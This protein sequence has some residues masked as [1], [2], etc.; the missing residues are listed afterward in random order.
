MNWNTRQGYNRI[1]NLPDY[2]IQTAFLAQQRAD[3]IALAEMSYSDAD[4]MTV[5]INDL[6][7][8]T[9]KSW[10]GYYQ[11]GNTETDPKTNNVGYA[12]LTWLPV[13]SVRQKLDVDS[14]QPYPTIEIQITVN[15]TKVHIAGTH[16]YPWDAS[17]RQTQIKSL[18][19][20]VSSASH[21][22]VIG[23]F[24]ANPTDPTWSATWTA[25]YTDAWI[26]ATN[27]WTQTTNDPG[28]TFDK[29]TATGVPERIDY[30]WTAGM[31][32]YDMA[33]VKTHRSDHHALVATFNVP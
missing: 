9:G 23:D 1:T 5:F 27:T 12:L 20:W 11:R 32:L 28:Y 18:Q 29:R 3:V 4:M 2:V 26:T 14:G 7:Q 21:R 30:Q 13:D 22:M 25:V 8:R 33:L 10:H 16:L 6:T 19:A 24:N 15:G 17:V 31:N